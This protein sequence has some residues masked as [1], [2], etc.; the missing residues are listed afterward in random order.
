MLSSS[1]ALSVGA[2]TVALGAAALA[3]APVAGAAPQAATPMCTTA[4]LTG[5]LGAGDV[6]AGQIYRDVVLTNHSSA[7]CHLTGFPGVSVLDAHGA[8]IGA[9]AT[10]EPRPYSLVVLAPGATATT[11]IHTTNR[12][13]NDPKECRPESTSLRVYPPGNRASL[14]FPAKLT[15]CNNTFTVTPLVGSTT[16]PS[17]S[18]TPT[19]VPSA[20][21]TPS[22]QVSAVPSGAP[23]TG[24][25]PTNSGGG[26]AGT[27]AAGAG[28]LLVLGGTGVAVARSRRS[29][30][31]G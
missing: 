16:A 26:S 10:H 14:V 21:A 8:Q 2:A 28:A 30:A 13:T 15:I 24:E 19:P 22:S 25:A 31:R 3:F 18:P 1:K 6:G 5:S 27:L 11:T 23:A 29:R 12:M 20:S 7:T 17:G 4:Q 9:P